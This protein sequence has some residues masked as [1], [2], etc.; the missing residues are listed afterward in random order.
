MHPQR[1]RDSLERWLAAC[2]VRDEHGR[3]VHLT[4]HQ[5]RHTLGTTLI[6]K[7]V[8]QPVVQR[9]L[10]HDSAEMT[11]HYARLSDKTVRRHWEAA[12]K[13]NHRGETVALDPDGP[14]AEAAWA[15]HRL[16]QATQSLPNGFC[17]LPLIK[18]CQHANACL[19]CPLFITTVEFLP[20]H[21]EQHQQTL[22]IIA[23]A[24]ARGQ[25]RMVEMNKQVADNLHRIITALETD[26]N[27]NTSG[28]SPD[29][30]DQTPA[31]VA[32]ARRRR[33]LTRAKAVRALREM[34]RAGSPVSFAAVAQAAGVSRSWLYTENDLRAEITRLRE[35]TADR[36]KTPP[37]PVSQRASEP[38]LRQR[39]ELAQQ[40]IRQLRNDNDRLRRELAHA[41]GGQRH[42]VRRRSDRPG[43]QP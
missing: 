17:G 23:K 3:P 33:E 29:A 24:E 14:L 10:D 27:G 35:A 16:A 9:I 39:L 34:E 22:Q 11:A 41:L 6:N 13:V 26:D 40:R 7:D 20:Q 38:S 37:I 18:T 43:E 21:R 5:W 25:A 2:D 12:R 31:M 15:K 36:P 8:P 32:A 4:P 1:Y 19:T 28:V 42:P 30:P